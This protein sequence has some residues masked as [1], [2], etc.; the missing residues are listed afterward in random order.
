MAK[1]K[2]YVVWSGRLPGVYTNWPQAQA[3]VDKFPGARYKSFPSEAEALAAFA[4]GVAPESQSSVVKQNR[5]AAKTA[6][7][8]DAVDVAVFCD[9]GCE[10]NPGE[11]GSG[12]AVYKCGQ[13]YELW[14]GLYNPNG[15]NNTAELNALY[16]SMLIAKQAIDEQKSVAVLSD[17]Q[18]SINCVTKWAP[19]WQRQGWVRPSGEIK[20]L[21]LIQQCFELYQQIEGRF[22]LRHVKAH[23]GTEG[24]ELADRMS[25]YA[26]EQ[27]DSEF[28]RYSEALDI[29]YILSLRAG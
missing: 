28:C 24:N 29:E 23:V 27:K 4:G 9:G 13:L 12:V 18:Y 21:Q 10:P 16:Q 1:K 17:S 7:D 25:I 15:T 6:V 19:G 8:I 11:A 5:A 3:Q 2:F 20:N 26:I 22:E 14:Y